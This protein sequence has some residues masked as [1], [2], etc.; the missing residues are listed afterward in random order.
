MLIV[1]RV[2]GLFSSPSLSFSSLHPVA[3]SSPSPSFRRRGEKQEEK[4][5]IMP[6]SLSFSPLL[7]SMVAS[8]LSPSRCMYVCVC[9]NERKKKLS[10]SVRLG[11]TLHLILL[12]DGV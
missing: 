3:F 4:A 1:V 2:L 11:H 6:T 9:M 10:L 7:F 8:F 5:G 12:L